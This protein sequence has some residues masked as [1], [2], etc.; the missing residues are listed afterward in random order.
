M[1]KQFDEKFIKEQ[2]EKL[3]KEKKELEKELSHLSERG[4]KSKDE[5]IVRYPKFNG[6]DIEEEADEVEE[7]G[8]LLSINYVLEKEL[9]RI[10]ESLEKIK[11]GNYGICEKCKKKIDKQRLKVCPQAKYCLKC[12]KN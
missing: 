1:N 11:K 2:K 3:L 9:K 5:W 12:H 10:N 7:Y 4:I 8:N 6:G